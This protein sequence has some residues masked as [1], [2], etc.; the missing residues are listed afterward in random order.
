M[1]IA[2]RKY[3]YYGKETKITMDDFIF[4]KL[5][6]LDYRAARLSKAQIGIR[7]DWEIE[8]LVPASG[9]EPILTV[10][11]ELDQAVD[12]VVCIISEPAAVEVPL[13]LVKT[14]WDELNW[15]YYQVWQ[16]SLPAHNEG[17]LVRYQII[18]RNARDP[19]AIPAS[20]DT[21]FS[22]LVGIPEPPNWSREA[23]IYQIMPDRFSPGSGRSWNQTTSTEGIY[24]GTIRGIIENLDYIQDLGINCLW[25]N[26]F[27]PDK[28]HHGY[29]ASDYFSVNPRLGSMDDTCELISES[30][31]R[32]IRV[33]MDFVANHWSSEHPYFIAA[34]E[35]PESEYYPW[36]FWK[37]WPHSYE[38]YYTV[39]SMPKL[40]VEHPGLRVYLRDS[41]IFWLSEI[42]FD[43]L[44]LDHAHGVSLNF[45]T[46]LR[47]EIKAKKPDAWLFGEVT[48]S[49]P[50]QLQFAG[51]LDGCLDFLLAQ[52]LRSVFAYERMSLSQLDA[53]LTAHE[54]YFPA[55]FSRPSFLD[56]HDMNRFL[57]MTDGDTRKLKLA[58][59]FLFSLPQPPII[60]YGTEAGVSQKNSVHGARSRGLSEARQPMKWGAD[61]DQDLHA[62]FKWLIHLRRDNPVLARGKRQTLHVDDGEGI[63]V[64]KRFDADQQ[65]IVAINFSEAAQDIEVD[66][67]S[68]QLPPISGD[69]HTS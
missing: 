15:S 5:K 69:I 42:G 50:H 8:P 49:A 32:G 46:W 22:Y 52:A 1:W 24:G 30:H 31:I 12:Q 19:D 61:Q 41:A 54:E 18:A 2:V 57:F 38:T 58:A 40:N 64:Y 14:D 65:I 44:R 21:V 34:Q 37:D 56:N 60:Y 35:D 51:R 67:R 23:V 27:F 62:Y 10:K 20:Q 39:K 63:Y 66:G 11:V 6:Q 26:P 33:L 28:T 25:L 3:S 45:W 29:Q 47:R 36:F 43:G 48:D 17:D 16:A 53:F 55:Y 4:G 13:K 68:F 7:H 59:L 9:E